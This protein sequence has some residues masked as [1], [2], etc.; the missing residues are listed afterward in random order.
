MKDHLISV[1]KV[2]KADRTAKYAVASPPPRR[3]QRNAYTNVSVRVY[4]S[5]KESIRR[6]SIDLA[7]Y[8]S[9]EMGR[10]MLDAIMSIS[11]EFSSSYAVQPPC[12]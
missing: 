6:I 3:Y 5:S 12:S 9:K 11:L 7:L 4:C 8:T 1:F 2:T 10:S